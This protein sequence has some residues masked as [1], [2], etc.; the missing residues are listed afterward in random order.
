MKFMFVAREKYS[1]GVLSRMPTVLNSRL[2]FSFI[3]GFG[4]ANGLLKGSYNILL[5]G[6]M[7]RDCEV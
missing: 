5:Y 2:L 1:R 3:F 4:Y 6:L 7:N